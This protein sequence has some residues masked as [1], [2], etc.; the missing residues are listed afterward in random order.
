MTGLRRCWVGML[1][2][3]VLGLG[4]HSSWA[5]GTEEDV[6][7]ARRLAQE[8]QAALDAKDYQTAVDKF[9]R[10][11]ALY[12]APSILV[13]LG[14]AYVGLGKFVRARE[15][16]NKVLR[17]QLA[18]DAPEAFVLAVKA[19]K[20]EVAPLEDKIAWVTIVV[21]GTSEPVVKLDGDEVPVAALGVKRAVDPGDHVV[22]AGA[23][24]FNGDE[25]RFSVQSGAS[26][27]VALT[28]TPAPAGG[29]P[30]ASGAAP[31]AGELA[32]AGDT[33]RLVGFVGIGVGAAGLVVGAITGGLALGKHSALVDA[34]PND[35][36]PP[37]EQ[38]NLDSYRTVG[39]VSTIG[40]IAGGVLAAAGVVVVLT[41]PSSAQE[42][43]PPAVSA[44]IGLGYIGAT[45]RF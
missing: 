30:V 31:A 13:G 8:G 16:Y 39:L 21:T 22:N 10:A 2:L 43:A 24:G 5:A 44:S 4:T 34:C 3:L 32:G 33:Q 41:A 20:A 15:S 40:F 11:E 27:D 23:E 38:D 36:C 35:Q 7:T 26:A 14:R 1:L 45:V 9:R 37:A 28:L 19:A 25:K 6:A 18:K 29:A 42:E 12:H 17:E